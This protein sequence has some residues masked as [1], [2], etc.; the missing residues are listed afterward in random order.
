[1]YNIMCWF[2]SGVFRTTVVKRRT[3]FTTERST[4]NTSGLRRDGGKTTR[5]ILL[6]SQNARKIFQ[7][8]HGTPHSTRV[9]WPPTASTPRRPADGRRRCGRSF[10]RTE[11]S[12]HC[13][14]VRM[15]PWSGIF[16]LSTTVV[17]NLRTKI[18]IEPIGERI[19]GG[20]LTPPTTTS[21]MYG[22]SL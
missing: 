9:P 4:K 2:N 13:A 7:D 22:I 1:M 5:G 15:D 20:V 11:R 3:V 8:C 10:V 17:K 18:V 16:L 21:K 14:T 12:A 6:K 19:A